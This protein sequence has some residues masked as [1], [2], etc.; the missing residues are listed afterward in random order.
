MAVGRVAASQLLLLGVVKQSN[1]WPSL[2]PDAGSPRIDSGQ[3][4]NREVATLAAVA[5]QLV[6]DVGEDQNSYQQAFGPKSI[7]LPA[8]TCRYG[9]LCTAR[10]L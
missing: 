5:H 3:Q 6:Q 2:D 7:C 1:A 9:L 10:Q 8:V 4:Q